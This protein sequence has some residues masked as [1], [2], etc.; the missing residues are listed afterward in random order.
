MFDSLL[1][2]RRPI[3]LAIGITVLGLLLLIAFAVLLLRS[4]DGNKPDETAEATATVSQEETGENTSPVSTSAPDVVVLGIS[5]SATIS[6]TLSTPMT[7]G[8][9]G[10]QFGLRAES[11]PT[12][13]RWQPQLV[14]TNTA[15]WVYGTVVN[16]VV[17]LADTAE[18][19]AL[20][21]GLAPGDLISLTTRGGAVSQFTFA[22]RDIVP[23]SSPD[24]FAQHTPGITLVLLGTEG[25]NRLVVHGR[26]VVPE[27]TSSSA[28]SVV[29][30]GETAQL[31]NVQITVLGTTHLANE[32]S[33]PPG[34]AF[35]LVDYELLNVGRDQVDLSR[36]R[37]ALIDQFGNQYAVN[38][39]A[40]QFGNHPLATGTLGADQRVEATVGYQIP[41]SLNTPTLRWVAQ[42]GESNGKV[43]VNLPFSRGEDA[44]AAV[45]TVLQAEVSLDGTSLTLQGQVTN[46]GAQR[47]VVEERV[48]SLS[49][50]GTV[51]LM[52]ANNPAFPWVVDAGQTIPFT[53]TFQ[54]PQEATAVLS[55]LNYPFELNGLR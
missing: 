53:L 10:E 45:V 26:Y 47:L 9:D 50:A 30:L 28:S 31:D 37:L 34:F 21:D 22:S 35:F 15:V 55:I 24:V 14:G 3:Y 18:T 1:E 44:N 23:A 4:P 2:G 7:L 19:R 17:G 11:V 52:F 41:A 54:R 5:N 42:Y 40:G 13:E 36:L 27:T 51:Y 20:M 38:A 33:T 49:S 48:V 8:V 39:L 25:D 16:Y 6:V 43:E 46:L 32:P 12:G 29:E